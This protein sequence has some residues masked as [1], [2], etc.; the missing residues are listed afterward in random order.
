MNTSLAFDTGFFSLSGELGLA[1]SAWLR[2][3]CIESWN[4]TCRGRPYMAPSLRKG[5]LVTQN[6]LRSFQAESQLNMTACMFACSGIR[7]NYLQSSSMALVRLFAIN[8][9]QSLAL[10][11]VCPNE[12]CKA[13]VKASYMDRLLPMEVKKKNDYLVSLKTL[14]LR[15]SSMRLRW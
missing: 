1:L 6:F 8:M 5:Y 11:Q 4:T 3:L 13:Q 14:T 15:P 10:W 2:Q 9:Q 7:D 12:Q